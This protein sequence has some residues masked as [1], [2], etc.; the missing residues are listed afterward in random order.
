[1]TNPWIP[2]T[3]KKSGFTLIELLV[4]I[5][6][7]GILAAAV[8]TRLDQAQA[9]ARDTQRISDMRQIRTALE[10][11][12]VD[13]GHYPDETVGVNHR[14]EF[15]GVGDTIDTLLS[16]YLNPVPRDPR[17][18]GVVHFYAYDPR[19][20]ISI[21]PN[22]TDFVDKISEGVVFGFNRSESGR[23]YL[24]GT[25]IGQDIN[26]GNADFNEAIYPYRYGM[27]LTP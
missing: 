15:I 25:C 6:I 16:P 20:D 9:Q 8:L 22:S 7:I 27:P 24:K 10:M 19:H 14:G 1:M 26:L 23:S 21:C 3:A 4:V 11:Y 5:A 13:Y 2:G 17:H 12:F 18:D